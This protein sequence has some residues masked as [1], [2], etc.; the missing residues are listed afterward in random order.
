[1]ACIPKESVSP[2]LALALFHILSGGGDKWIK[3]H[4]ICA[5]GERFNGAER[6]GHFLMHIDLMHIFQTFKY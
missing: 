5:K 6:E 1:M 3:C 4:F 2:K